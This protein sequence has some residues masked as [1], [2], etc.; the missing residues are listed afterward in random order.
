MVS[1]CTPSSSNPKILRCDAV[2]RQSWIWQRDPISLQ[3]M[4]NPN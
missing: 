2:K 4:S 3:S 1:G